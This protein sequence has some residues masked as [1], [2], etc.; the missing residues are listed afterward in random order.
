[1]IYALISQFD[2]IWF[3][4]MLNFKQICYATYRIKILFFFYSYKQ[5]NLSKRKDK[6]R[7]QNTR[8]LPKLLIKKI[9]IN[10]YNLSILF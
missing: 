4:K 7:F 9:M 1:M 2:I 3:Y 10:T 6:A 8:V 5:E